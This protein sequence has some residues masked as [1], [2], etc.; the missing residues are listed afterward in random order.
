MCGIYTRGAYKSSCD[1]DYRYWYSFNRIISPMGGLGIKDMTHQQR[2]THRLKIAK[3]Q[4][5]TVLKM[6]EEG[7]YC[8]DVIYQSRAVQSALREIDYLI[9]ENHLQTCVVDFVKKGKT[10][11]S[12]REIIKI[13]RSSNE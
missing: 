13:F 10:K 5:D 1:L 7:R 6:A 8:I 11:Q 12:V 4:L 9:L 2:V 3:G